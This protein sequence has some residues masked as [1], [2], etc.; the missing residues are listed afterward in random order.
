VINEFKLFHLIDSPFYNSR[1]KAVNISNYKQSGLYT[2]FV[3]NQFYPALMPESGKLVSLTVT[4]NNIVNEINESIG[5]ENEIV[6][7]NPHSTKISDNYV[8]YGQV[9]RIMLTEKLYDLYLEA[10]NFQLAIDRPLLLLKDEPSGKKVVPTSQFRHFNV[11]SFTS[12][13]P[14]AFDCTYNVMLF[15]LTKENFRHS[16]RRV[17][18][19][20]GKGK[21]DSVLVPVDV[22]YLNNNSPGFCEMVVN[23][24]FQIY[25]KLVSMGEGLYIGHFYSIYN[26]KKHDDL[27][28]SINIL[29]KAFFFDYS[30]DTLLPFFISDIQKSGISI[31]AKISKSISDK[32]RSSVLKGFHESIK[33]IRT[34]KSWYKISQEGDFIRANFVSPKIIFRLLNAYAIFQSDREMLKKILN[35]ENLIESISNFL[36]AIESNMFYEGNLINA[37][38]KNFLEMPLGDE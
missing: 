34:A 5:K 8:S 26:L 10:L 31:R 3:A 18:I 24:E 21:I 1:V 25:K 20:L 38:L 19:E 37:S 30:Y 33:E 13:G 29:T 2:I 15:K 6:F 35:S 7:V 23:C 16:E 32:M 28:D 17:K 36:N 11:K 22:F 12:D 14:I 9:H 4:S 27:Q